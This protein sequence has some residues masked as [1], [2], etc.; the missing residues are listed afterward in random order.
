MTDD[1]EALTLVAQLAGSGRDTCVANGSSPTAKI[2]STRKISG[3]SVHGNREGQTQEHSRGVKL[4]LI[5]N[6]IFD[7]AE[8]DDSIELLVDLR[9]GHAENGPI[10]EDVFSPRRD[11]GETRLPR[12]SDRRC[13]RAPQSGPRLPMTPEI[14]LS[15]VD[16]PEPFRPSSATAS[17]SPTVSEMS[18]NAVNCSRGASP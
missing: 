7:L 2:S 8:G 11:P 13:C 9:L 17:P 18:R 15:S 16:F 14:N 3:I 1:N 4:H 6:E 5:V 12:Q 10:E